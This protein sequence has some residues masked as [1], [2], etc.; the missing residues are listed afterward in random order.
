MAGALEQV[1][2]LA[3]RRVLV[4]G[5]SGGIGRACARLLASAGAEV[6]A[7]GRDEKRL[8]E[9]V[10]GLET[11]A[12]A[13]PGDLTDAQACAEIV[14]TLR[15]AGGLDGLVHCAGVLDLTPA[16]FLKAEKL[17]ATMDTN[18]SSLAVLVRELLAGKVV[19]DRAS[20]VFVSSVIT[21]TAAAGHAAYAASKGALEAYAR[22]LALE[23]A[24]RA[25]RVNCVAPAMVRTKMADA[26]ARGV[27]QS[28]FDE[29]ARA[30]PLGLGEPEDVAAMALFLLGDGAR[31]ITGQTIVADGGF[32]LK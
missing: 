18:F 6:F 28:N 22:V 16:K 15:E 27:S 20:L 8:A 23:L 2:G 31:W 26:S 9:T 4:T 10:E 32:S 25:V 1:F 30:Y 7:N 24:P 29:H 17:A 5:A 13:C 12:T 14:T 3:G 21:R 11:Q 19:A